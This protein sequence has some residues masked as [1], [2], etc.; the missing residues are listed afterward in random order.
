M[1]TVIFLCL[2]IVV[3][4]GNKYRST[5]IWVVIERGG[6]VSDLN[7]K[8]KSFC[9]EFIK[10]FNITNAAIRAGY[11]KNSAHVTGSRLL[12]N[13]KVQAYLSKLKHERQE[14]TQITQDRIV[15][16]LARIAFG[17]IRDILTWDHEKGRVYLKPM[18]E[19]GD[20][21]TMIDEIKE[22]EN[23]ISVKRPDR[24]K[25][26]EM[27]AR[28]IGLYDNPPQQQVDVTAYVQALGAAAGNVWA[29]AEHTESQSDE[30]D[31]QGE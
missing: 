14:R 10:D 2:L 31:E 30:N 23:G 24:M 17:D 11:A 9:N 5:H 21:G 25:A 13:D 16:G 28:H 18:D 6:N 26:Y 12:K 3:Y 7:D 15:E 27:L 1:L 29:N 19:I 8:Q 20:A 4:N 22:T